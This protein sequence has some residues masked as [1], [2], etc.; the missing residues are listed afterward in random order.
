MAVKTPKKI[1]LPTTLGACADRLF[2]VR[3]E[4]LKEQKALEPL[5]QE[6]SALKDHIIETL[7]KSKASGVAG[8]LARVS[9]TTSPVPTVE[10]WDKLYAYVKKTGEWDLLGR[11]I[12]AEA[13]RLRW[14]AKKKV[15]GVGVFNV[16]S[17]SINKL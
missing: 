12:N 9:V 15:P 5:K 13:V 3:N 10:D 2:T 7:P 8:K 17:V 11:T 16:V 14:E 4:R 1:K 6:E